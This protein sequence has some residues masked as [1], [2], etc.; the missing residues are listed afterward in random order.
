MEK[1]KISKKRRLNRSKILIILIFVVILILCI[2]FLKK[3][4]LIS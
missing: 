3:K 1:R 2:K 4:I